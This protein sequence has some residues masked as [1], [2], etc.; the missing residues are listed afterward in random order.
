[1]YL[2]RLTLE[3]ELHREA[4]SA[5]M[6]KQEMSSYCATWRRKSLRV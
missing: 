5:I 2:S 1:M 4:P 6:P 3:S